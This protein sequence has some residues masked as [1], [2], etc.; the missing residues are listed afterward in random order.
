[1][2]LKYASTPQVNYGGNQGSGNPFARF[3]EGARPIATAPETSTPLIIYESNGAG[4]WAMH[5]SGAWRKL[6]PFKDWRTG[7]VSWRMD[8]TMI[9]NPVAWGMPRKN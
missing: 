6:A 9:N 8:G 5:Y 2:V 4:H 1:M 3:P 7:A